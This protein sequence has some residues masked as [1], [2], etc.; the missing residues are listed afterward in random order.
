MALVAK[1]IQ[2][3]EV[4]SLTQWI[5]AVPVFGIHRKVLGGHNLAAVLRPGDFRIGD[6]NRTSISYHLHHI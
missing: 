2:P 3:P 5:L 1:E 4:I 6:A